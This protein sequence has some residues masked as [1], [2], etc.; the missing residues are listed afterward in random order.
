MAEW[1][2]E[3]DLLEPYKTTKGFSYLT[4]DLEP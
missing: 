2:Q 3:K 1:N 4:G